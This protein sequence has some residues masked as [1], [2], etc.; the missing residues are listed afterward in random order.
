MKSNNFSA[1]QL[2]ALRE[3]G[4]IGAGNAA[5]SLSQLV[6]KS[7]NLVVPSVNI[8]SYD[9]MME[10]VGGPEETV[11]AVLFR[12]EGDLPCTVIFIMT[13]EEAQNLVKSLIG[14]S[15]EFSS[16]EDVLSHQM[17]ISALEEV[18]NIVTGSYI[19]A[20]S[21]FINMPL[22]PSIPHLGI[23]MAAAVLTYGLVEASQASD[24][25]IIINT[26]M[27]SDEINNQIKGHFFLLPDPGAIE[28]LFKSLGI[29][30]YD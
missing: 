16:D 25:A 9:D 8:V 30:Q 11:V 26:K 1:L 24:Y 17:S 7:I 3:I 22:K 15:Y 19:S 27:N 28:V 18:G 5:T 6:N 12:V 10:F 23:D 4:N 29:N 13:V 2:D 14:D 21:D 20:L